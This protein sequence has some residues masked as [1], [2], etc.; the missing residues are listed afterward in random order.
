MA[1]RD[2]EALDAR[3]TSGRRELK[4]LITPDQAR[5][6]ACE[7]NAQLESH[8]HRGEG[9]NLL[10]AAH[11]YVT[12]IYFDTASRTLFRAARQTA[13]V[14]LKL[15]AKEYYDLHPGLT[16]TATDPRELVRYQRILWLE[17][18][19]KSGTQTGKQ[20]VGIPKADVP[21]FFARGA[22]TSEMVKIQEDAYGAEAHAVLRAVAELCASCGEPLEV[23]CLVNYRRN[24]WQDPSAELRVTIDTGLAFF[25]PAPDLWDRDF[26]VVRPTLGAAI[27][28]EARRVLEIKSH[29]EPPAWLARALRASAI[30]ATSFSKFEASSSAV[31][32]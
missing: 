32:G 24:A 15:R 12:T 5:A 31:H 22:I 3:M 25:A 8:R 6:L 30:E 26:A 9:A 29:G 18:K 16:E 21:G 11:H 10:P 1:A 2:G 19:H 20:R 4:Y 17:L 27:A 28:T 13:D 14:H 7:L 23:D